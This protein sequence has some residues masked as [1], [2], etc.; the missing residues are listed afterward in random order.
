MF[1]TSRIYSQSLLIFD[2]MASFC[3]SLHA[4]FISNIT[5][6]SENEAIQIKTVIASLCQSS[7]NINAVAKDISSLITPRHERLITLLFAANMDVEN[8]ITMKWHEPFLISSQM[9]NTTSA[10]HSQDAPQFANS[11]QESVVTVKSSHDSM[12]MIADQFEIEVAA[13]VELARE[14]LKSAELLCH[15]LRKSNCQQVLEK[16]LEQRASLSKET[17]LCQRV[18]EDYPNSKEHIPLNEKFNTHSM[19]M[20]GLLQAFDALI[21]S[22]QKRNCSEFRIH[23]KA[24]EDSKQTTM[25]TFLFTMAQHRA[26]TTRKPKQTAAEG[27]AVAAEKGLPA[28]HARRRGQSVFQEDEALCDD[29]RSSDSQNAEFSPSPHSSDDERVVNAPKSPE[30]SQRHPRFKVA[31]SEFRAAGAGAKSHFLYMFTASKE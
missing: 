12:P 23:L 2:L 15:N 6:L 31:R 19:V 10:Q 20:T 7:S 13:R 24:K 11:S 18:A 4:I 16:L 9:L 17:C 21:H 28:R 14:A 25:D 29:D 1:Q 27:S 3:N 30:D 8:F 5:Q 22:T 26:P